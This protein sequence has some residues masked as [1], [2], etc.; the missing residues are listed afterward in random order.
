[1]SKYRWAGE[2]WEPKEVA[3]AAYRAANQGRY[4][5]ANAFLAPELLTRLTQPGT[6]ALRE[7]KAL[8]RRLRELKGRRGDVAARDRE[9]IRRLIELNQRIV[10]IGL[11]SPRDLRER[12][13][14]VTR[15]GS[16][17]RIEAARQLVRGSRARVYL[18]LTLPDG[19]VVRDSEPL[20]QRRGKWLLG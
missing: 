5:A 6:R 2:S 20:I 12:W 19:S 11:G 9:S 3:V 15:G 7:N 16:L 18:K 10:R 4:A 13:R 1:L 17:V 8:R 14:E